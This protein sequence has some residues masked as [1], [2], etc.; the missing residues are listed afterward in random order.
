MVCP[1]FCNDMHS[2][3]VYFRETQRF[4]QPWLWIILALPMVAAIAIPL[5]TEGL[6]HMEDFIGVGITAAIIL[7]MRLTKLETRL[8]STGITV[9]FFPFHRKP[10]FFPL[11]NIAS[12][13]VTSYRPIRDYGGW[14]L[15]VGAKGA[16]FNT[17]GKNGMLVGFR[18]AQ[19]LVLGKQKNLM[20]GTQ[21]P[22]ALTKAIEE[23]KRA[24]VSP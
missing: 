5:A 10:R 18:E 22:E 12:M 16:A 21:H 15:R 14:G 1:Y 11:D 8:D 24:A 20:I 3:T 13:E 17:S 6:L 4:N 2:P 7:L 19:W 23:L 9:R